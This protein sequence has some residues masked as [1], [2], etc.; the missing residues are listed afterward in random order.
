MTELFGQCLLTRCS[1]D[2]F[3]DVI[4][5]ESTYIRILIDD[6]EFLKNADDLFFQEIPGGEPVLDDIQSR[7]NIVCGC[8]N[9]FVRI[10]IKSFRLGV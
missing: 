4:L 8:E 1:S 6:L 5:Y 10:F 3:F 9:S 7:L 2:N